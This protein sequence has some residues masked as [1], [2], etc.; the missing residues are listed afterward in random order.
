LKEFRSAI[1]GILSSDEDLS[2]FYLSYKRATNLPRPIKDHTE[3]EML[4]E[5]YSKKGK[6][7]ISLEILDLVSSGRNGQ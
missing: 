7:L 6:T 5:N 4:L 3:I 2:N 1:D